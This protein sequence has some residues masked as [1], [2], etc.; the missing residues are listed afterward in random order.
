MKMP[1]LVI[2]QFN[3]SK[4]HLT[5][6]LCPTD[7]FTN[8]PEAHIK[9]KLH[10]D[11]IIWTKAW[12]AYS[13]QQW[14]DMIWKMAEFIFK[15]PNRVPNLRFR[16]TSMSESS[17]KMLA[18]CQVFFFQKCEKISKKWKSSFIRFTF[19]IANLFHIIS[20]HCWIL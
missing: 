4:T 18:W 10:Q 5:I 19:W 13:I 3:L 16:L 2:L 11:L 1:S 17:D 7:L 8:E 20:Y 15:L 14:Y 6:E 9:Q 12:M